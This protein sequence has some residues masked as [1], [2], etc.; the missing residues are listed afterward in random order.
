MSA[1]AARSTHC[2]TIGEPMEKPHIPTLQELEALFAKDDA[3]LTY[4]APPNPAR[5]QTAVRAFLSAWDDDL[6]VRELAPFV[7]EVRRALEGRP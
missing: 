1:L 6:T 2:L 3:P 4:R 7:E 5:L